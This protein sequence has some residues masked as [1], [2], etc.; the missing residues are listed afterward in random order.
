MMNKVS[1]KIISDAENNAAEIMKSNDLIIEEILNNQK[2]KLHTLSLKMEQDLKDL[3][4]REIKKLNAISEI[5]I[6]K[7]ILSAKREVIN[8]LK[9]KVLY[10]FLNDKSLY[11]RFIKRAVEQGAFTGNEEII[12]S[13]ED[14]NLFTSEFL[15]EL[16]S[17]SSGKPGRDGNL[18]LSEERLSAGRGILLR[19]GRIT[20][21]AVLENVI[22]DTLDEYEPDIVRIYATLS[23]GEK[24]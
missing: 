5:E 23:S 15:R 24:G 22:R 3:Y 20:Y 9:D 19:E 11:I 2:E 14:E 7:K 1:E 8:E 4:D 6:K 13:K 18:K 21:D 10:K 12:I 17:E 16:N